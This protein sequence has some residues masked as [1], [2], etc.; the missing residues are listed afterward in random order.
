[1]LVIDDSETAR[2]AIRELLEQADY[3]VVV[4]P[5]AIGATRVILQQQIEAAIIDLSMPGLS[6]DRLVSVLRGNPRLTNLVLILVSG[7]EESALQSL[8]HK[9]DVQG[10]MGKGSVK[11]ELIPLLGRLFARQRSGAVV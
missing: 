4:L 6:G 8:R 9:I 7:E 3:D 11:Y 1:M 10:V 5:S 2:Q